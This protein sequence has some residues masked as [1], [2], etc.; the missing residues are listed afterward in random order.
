LY[1]PYDRSP[2]EGLLGVMTATATAA[3][4]LT[5]Q[6]SNTG[7]VGDAGVAANEFR[8]F[9]I[10]IVEDTAI[11]TA[12][13]QRRAISSHTAG[14][15]SVYTLNANWTVT[16][17]ATAKYVIEN[18][19]WWL[20]QPQGATICYIFR[21]ATYCA[22]G[23]GL[24]NAA[25]LT[26]RGAVA[27]AGVTLIPSYGMQQNNQIAAADAA[28]RPA[29]Y[30]QVHSFRGGGVGTLDIIDI[31][32]QSITAT[33][34]DVRGAT[35]TTGNSY[36][37]APACCEGRFAYLN[38]ASQSANYRY[39]VKNRVLSQWSAVPVALGTMVV[40]QRMAT[41]LFVDGATKINRL[42]M[43]GI[44]TVGFFDVMVTGY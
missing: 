16:P 32:A 20:W 41:A 36:S 6:A 4:T 3:G 5:G 27:G 40:G 7:N 38:A 34:I 14:A 28:S 21:E 26:G 39:D 33:A 37:Y 24:W 9:Q 15:S 11:P 10:R 13:G 19:N 43:L 25:I 18:P 44:G 2:G 35:F 22:V 17:S 23:D 31:A 42:L 1:V 12:V 30:S 29:R 8:N